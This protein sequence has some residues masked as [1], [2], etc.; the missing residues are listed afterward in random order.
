MIHNKMWTKLDHSYESFE[1]NNKWQNQVCSLLN[2]NIFFLMNKS[3]PFC[4]PAL[5]WFCNFDQAQFAAFYFFWFVLSF[6][7]A[8]D[9]PPTQ[10]DPGIRSLHSFIISGETKSPMTSVSSMN[11]RQRRPVIDSSKKFS[12]NWCFCTENPFS[13]DAFSC[14]NTKTLLLNPQIWDKSEFEPK[15][16]Q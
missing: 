7:N 9:F 14:G 12:H 4:I 6:G 11:E 3:F 2:A 16:F 1:P 5:L 10:C 8:S 13:T 15:W